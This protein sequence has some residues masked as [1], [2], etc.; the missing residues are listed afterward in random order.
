MTRRLGATVVVLAVVLA[1][2]GSGGGEATPDTAAAPGRS[3]TAP[4]DVLTI[5]HPETLAF[6]APFT[7]LP[8]D[9]PLDAVARKTDVGTW[10]TPDVLRSLLVNG[11]SDVTAVPTYVGANLYNKGID[12]RMAAV[13]VW[14]LL[15]VVGPDGSAKSWDSLRGQTVMVPFRDDMPDLV[16]RRLALENGL[17]PGRAFKVEYYA[18]PPEVV[19]RL[20]AGKGKWAVL[21]EHVATLALAGAGRQ[22]R[23]LGRILD[24]QAEWATATDAGSPR[25]PQA[26]V[27]VPGK[28][29]RERPDV[30]R[31]V[32]EALVRS[33]ALVNEAAPATVAELA[34]FS[35]LPAPV[36]AEVIP[37]LNL[38]VVP[39][40]D[41][42][43]ELERF[44]EELAELNPDIIGGRLP[45]RSFYLG[46]TR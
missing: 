14:G 40:A 44:F 18:Q 5:R 27:V 19:Q 26:G 1:A 20:V 12:V 37:R 25:I 9:G 39:A 15:W 10:S 29:A 23:S 36:V 4:L 28:L 46:A 41:A 38:D 31:A 33:V 32:V 13:V 42:R 22:G 21:P 24:L 6:A 11:R 45:D 8:S 30:V 17:E 2:C 16:F 7:V 43:E 34:E 3:T 35:G